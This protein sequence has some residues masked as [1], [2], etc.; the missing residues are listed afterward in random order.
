M[1]FFAE[2]NRELITWGSDSV[3]KAW[4][5]FRAVAADDPKRTLLGMEDL[6]FAIRRDIGHTN[7]GLEQGD[8]LRVFV[9]DLGDNAESLV[10]KAIESTAS[11]VVT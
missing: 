5:K 7:S 6:V 8:I 3:L 11:E 4:V 10:A 9:N 1:A 2:F